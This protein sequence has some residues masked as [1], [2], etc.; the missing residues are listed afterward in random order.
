MNCMICGKV[1]PP[2]RRAYCSDACRDER[3]RRYWQA[4]IEA[5][6]KVVGYRPE[7]WPAIALEKLQENP[8]CQ[9]CGVTH[10]LEVHHVRPLASGGSNELSNLM[11]LCHPCHRA[12][13]GSKPRTG[14]IS[15]TIQGA[16]E[17]A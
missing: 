14:D 16:L 8:K 13:H 15:K 10:D 12:Q 4:K 1:L 3:W 7:T 2:R 9:R 5:G 6:K 17:V 11:V